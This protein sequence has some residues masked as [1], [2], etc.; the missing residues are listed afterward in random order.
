MNQFIRVPQVRCIQ[1]DGTNSIMA[2]RD[3]LMLAQRLDLDL[4]EVTPNA[5]PPVCKI[6]DYGKFKYEQE[7]KKKE[8]R[9][10]QKAQQVKE[11]KFHANTDVG[12]YNLKIRNIRAFLAEGCKVK[13]T[14]Q[15]RGRENAHKELGTELMEKVVAD[16]S[17]VAQ[18][19]QPPKL[20]GRTISGLI[21]PKSLKKG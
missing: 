20:M 1:P 7:R 8:E 21:G 18:I 12:D 9:K 19:D 10:A 6:M 5:M 2:T 3:A 4:V 11:I 13:L 14:L 15:F 17:D 16:L